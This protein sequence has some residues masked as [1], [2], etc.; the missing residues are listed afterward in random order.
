MVDWATI[1]FSLLIIVI[2]IVCYIANVKGKFNEFR[3]SHFLFAGSAA[4]L[5]VVD[6]IQTWTALQ[7]N[8]EGNPLLMYIIEGFPGGVGW[9][10]FILIH[11][12]FCVL[13]FYLGWKG[14][15]EHAVDERT[16]AAF[17]GSLWAILVVWNLA[18][19]LFYRVI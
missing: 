10:L 7:L 9:S 15:S 4:I 11:L 19:M 16:V 1:L 18:F 6:I 13:G 17:L 5:P 3:K 14:R 2:L 8:A 12:A